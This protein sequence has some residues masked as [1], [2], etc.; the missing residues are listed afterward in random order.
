MD[1]DPDPTPFFIDFKDAKKNLSSFFCLLT[2][3]QAHYLQSK[4]F[5]FF[6]KILCT[7]FIC[8]HYF[9]PLKKHIYE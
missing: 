7:N 1:P 3:P 6:A 5:K 8:R 9:R 2:S 4:L